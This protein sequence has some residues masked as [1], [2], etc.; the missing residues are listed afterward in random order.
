MWKF[1]KLQLVGS[2][3][4]NSVIYK[5]VFFD[6]KSYQFKKKMTFQ[7]QSVIQVL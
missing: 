6:G 5:V 3:C 1:G 7:I 2:G 4:D